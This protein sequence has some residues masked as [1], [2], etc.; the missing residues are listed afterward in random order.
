MI[1]SKDI[2]NNFKKKKINFFT[3]VPDS[4]LK[5]LTVLFDKKKNI[6]HVVAVNEGSAIS[7]ATGY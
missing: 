2:I 1:S 5:D 6:K 7:I 3:G 4:V